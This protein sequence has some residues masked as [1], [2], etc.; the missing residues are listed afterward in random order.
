MTRMSSSC[1]SGEEEGM[2]NARRHQPLNLM[3]GELQGMRKE[4][5]I[6]LFLSRVF[7]VFFFSLLRPSHFIEKLRNDRKKGTI[8]LRTY[9][10]AILT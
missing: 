1:E 8:F 7:A 9:N 6:L 5:Q 3:T 4:P 2:R 10:A